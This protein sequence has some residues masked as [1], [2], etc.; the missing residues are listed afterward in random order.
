[1][2][3][4]L[5]EEESFVYLK[6]HGLV[7]VGSS[8]WSFVRDSFKNRFSDDEI[9]E[10]LGVVE[11][12]SGDS[13]SLN[14]LSGS[15]GVSA[16]NWPLEAREGSNLYPLKEL[17]EERDGR[18]KNEEFDFKESCDAEI[19]GG[20]SHSSFSSEGYLS[21][22]DELEDPGFSCDIFEGE[23]VGISSLETDETTVSL[24]LEE[25]EI[26]ELTES[27]VQEKLKP[28]LEEIVESLKLKKKAG[29]DWEKYEELFNRLEQLVREAR[30]ELRMDIEGASDLDLFLA[31]ILTA[32]VIDLRK[33]EAILNAYDSDTSYEFEDD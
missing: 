9:R 6:A 14:K 3:K 16:S 30:Q 31:R 2:D 11:C 18:F 10:F 20:V 1:M 27:G 26:V 23:E 13:S 15:S 7:C 24:E 17:T 8:V 29:S 19:V 28:N 4:E 33:V 25:T 32:D 22:S 5:E 12:S 21:V